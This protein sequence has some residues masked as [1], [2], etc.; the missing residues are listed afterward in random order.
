MA[1]S[2][3]LSYLTN[4]TTTIKYCKVYERKKIIPLREEPMKMSF[5]Y[6]YS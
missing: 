6:L 5:E 4:V 3:N 2:E 1:S